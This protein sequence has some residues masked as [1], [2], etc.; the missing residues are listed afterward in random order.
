MVENHDPKHGIEDSEKHKGSDAFPERRRLCN[1][2]GRSE[3]FRHVHAPDGE[4]G[5]AVRGNQMQQ[6]FVFFRIDKAQEGH[7][8][9]E[10]D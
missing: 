10:G 4:E 9:Q 1:G 5:A 6:V 2:T 8:S 7:D 3:D